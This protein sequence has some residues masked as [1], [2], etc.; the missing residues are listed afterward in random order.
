[1]L[2][3][4]SKEHIGTAELAK[5]LEESRGR[6]DGAPDAAVAHPHLAGC[7]RCREQYEGLRLLNR[8]LESISAPQSSER[9][10]S[11]PDHTVWREIAG[12]ITPP[13]QTLVCLE[14]ASRCGQCGPLLRQAVA[15]LTA[16]KGEMTDAERKHIATLESA[17]E[18]WQHSLVQRITGTRNSTRADRPA[19]WWRLSFPRLALTLTFASLVAV[20]GVGSW[21]LIQR[22]QP[23]TARQL[24]VRAYTEK[25]TFEP[26]IAGAEYAPLRISRGSG[27]SFTSRSPSL[28]QAEALIASQLEIHPSNPSWL[29]AQAQAELLEG[30]YDAAVDA[31]HHALELEPNSPALLTDAATA[32]FQR[33]LDGGHQDDLSTAFEYLT[34]VLNLHPDDPVALFNRA[35]VSEHQFLNHRALEDWQHYLRVDS[36]SQWAEEARSR[37]NAIQE[38]LNQHGSAPAPL[39]SPDQLAAVA[40]NAELDS[41][42]DKRIEEYLH[43]A[44]R[45]WI[46]QA[47]PEGRAPDGANRSALR[48]LFFL[49]DLTSRQHG[50]HWLADF[51]RSSSNPHFRHAANEL[52]SAVQADDAGDY[53]VSRQHEVVAEQLFRALDNSAGALRSEFE[54]I[55]SAQVERRSEQC[56]LDASGALSESE[57][58]KYPW[59]QIQLG[60]EKGVCSGLMGDIGTD[61][62]SSRRA[63][64]RAQKNG[65]GALYLRALG[66]VVEDQLESGETTAGTKLANA[67]L[68]RFWS[69]PYPVMRGYNLYTVLAYQAE[70][71]GHSAVRAAMWREAVALIDF[72]HDLLL[73]AKAHSSLASAATA[74]RLPQLAQEQYAEAAKLFLASPRTEATRNFVLE[75]EVR[76]AQLEARQGQFD[77][78][79][80][81]L[82]RIQEQVRSL[83]NNYLVQMFYSTLGELQLSGHRDAEAE[84]ALRPALALAEQTLSTLGSEAQR[85]NWS[86]DAAPAYLSLIEAQIAQGHSQQALETYEW[87]LGAAQRG[88]QPGEANRQSGASYQPVTDPPMP[89]PAS[90]AARIPLLAKVTVLTYAAMPGGIAIWAYDDRGITAHWIP[91]STIQLQELAERFHDLASDPKSDLSALHRDAR[92]LYN[93]LISPVEQRFDSGRTLVIET[94]GWMARIPFEALMDSHEHYLIERT[95]IVHSLGQDSGTRLRNNRVISADMA[96]LVVGSSASSSA[97][98][99]IP[100]PDVASEADLVAANF[101]SALELKGKEANLRALQDALPAALIFHFAGHSF[102][103]PERAGLMLEAQSGQARLQLLDADALR[104]IAVPNLQLAML[105]ACGTGEGSDA[106]GGFNSVTE[107]FLRAGVPHVIASRWAI[108]SMESR[109]FVGNFYT[110]L[111]SGAPVSEAIRTTSRRMLANPQTSHPYYW[112]AF[113]A[114]GER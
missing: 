62:A 38:K 4:N 73:R 79:I 93:A 114:Y 3:D 51:L 57:T 91:E 100:L 98:G 13:D 49:A 16:L 72:D 75:T 15:D 40:A 96:A 50:D 11:C 87:Y 47:F 12:G 55:F 83:S 113:A 1:V 80:A 82:T 94:D 95:S 63:M 102:A 65:Y 107:A 89:E 103:N 34:R 77:S 90:L 39:L 17:R 106:S 81:R 101:H 9:R 52:A 86:K 35:L 61:E 92:S 6:P 36:S 66:F 108:D 32:Y 44:I 56:R 109:D 41:E 58:H 26:R 71:I 104:N 42:V 43:E 105:S 46:P 111:L 14:H 27:A 112:S 30:K 21:L 78:A 7:G 54:R 22:N 97:N 31:L 85:S 29:Q 53:D 60:L 48:A 70:G 28:L 10:G 5:L 59:L 64:D 67:G 24:L 69:A 2:E 76:T 18:E 23:A 74:A 33:A 45:S 37:A 99:L 19:A 88:T 110:N 25:R 68:E 84:Q 20:I 8:Q